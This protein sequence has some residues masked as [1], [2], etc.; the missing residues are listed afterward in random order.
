MAPCTAV[1]MMIC[2]FDMIFEYFK[3]FRRL[4]NVAITREQ[5]DMKYIE[6]RHIVSIK[7]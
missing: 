5:V 4:K 2:N 7:S 3:Y 6:E 1:A